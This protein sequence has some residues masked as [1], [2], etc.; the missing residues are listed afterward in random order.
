[1]MSARVLKH[2]H[3]TGRFYRAS[4][5][6]FEAVIAFYGRTLQVILRHQT[7]TLLVAAG[8]LVLTTYQFI[9]IPKGFFP[10]QDTGII[11]GVSEAPQAISFHAMSERQQ[12]L[13]AII[14]KDPAVE[15][16]SSFIGI[17]GTNLTLNSGRIQINLKPLE[18]RRIDV[19]R[20]DRAPPTGTGESM[21]SPVHATRTGS[22]RRRPRQLHAISADSRRSEYGR[23]ERLCAAHG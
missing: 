2:T 16:I 6:A 23:A 4:E 9:E 17:D 11:Q 15:S 5:R 12:R 8:T 1:M 10:I 21:V 3:Q 14:L 18:E 7:A 13:A 19:P 22:V 20:R